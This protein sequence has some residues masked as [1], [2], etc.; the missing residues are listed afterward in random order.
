[1]SGS[2]LSRGNLLIDTVFGLNITPPASI[3][4]TAATAG[5]YTVQG[6]QLGDLVQPV[7]T[8]AITTYSMINSWVS[9]A[10]TLTIYFSSETGATVSGAAA[11]NIAVNWQRYEGGAQAFLP[12]NAL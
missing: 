12:T 6:L 1:M 8:S 10:N 3:V 7:F 4:T 11:V 9:A 5:N 2:Q